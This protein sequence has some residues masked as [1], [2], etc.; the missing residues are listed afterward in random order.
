MITVVFDTETTGLLKPSANHVDEQPEI[1][2]LYACKLDDEYNLLEEFDSF[3]KP[4]IPLTEELTRIHGITNDM[5]ANAPKFE[6]KYE[7]LAKFMTGVDEIVAH[8]LAFDRSMLANELIRIDRLIQFPWPRIHT[9]TVEMSMSIEQRRM[10]LKTL[11][12]YAT[13]KEHE[14]QHR[15]KSDVFALVR[16]LHWMRDEKKL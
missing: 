3:F 2:E 16:C 12:S 13:G 5:I 7:E 8:N 6:D 14:G 10:N 15:A 1:V 4:K 11:H 9:C